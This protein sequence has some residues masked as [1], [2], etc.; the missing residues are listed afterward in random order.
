MIG[1]VGVPAPDQDAPDK[2]REREIRK[3]VMSGQRKEARFLDRGGMDESFGRRKKVVRHVALDRERQ[4]RVELFRLE[5]VLQ[6]CLEILILAKL[7]RLQRPLQIPGREFGKPAGK[8]EFV[9]EDI[10]QVRFLL[11]EDIGERPCALDPVGQN[12]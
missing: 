8:A 4:D 12:H 6:D 2:L 3:D 9:P 7:Y 11:V 10:L 5:I 1:F